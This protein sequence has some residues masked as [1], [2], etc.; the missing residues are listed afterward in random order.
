MSRTRLSVLLLDSHG[1]HSQAVA[2]C[3]GQIPQL[4]LHALSDIRW[5]AVRFSRVISSFHRYRDVGSETAQLADIRCVSRAVR[6]DVLLPV[7]ESSLSLLARHRD[8]FPHNLH[9]PPLSSPE[10]LATVANKFTLARRLEQRALPSPPTLLFTSLPA[11]ASDFRRLVFPALLKPLAGGGGCGIRRF[12]NSPALLQAL[13]AHPPEPAS[14]ILQAFVPGR[15]V[16]C[17]VLCRDGRILAHTIQTRL[18]PGPSRFTVDGAMT[19]TAHPAALAAVE[20]TM[21][22]LRW[23]GIAHL[24]LREDERDGSVQIIDFNPRYWLTL[25]GSLT[26]GVNFPH[27][28]CLTTLGIEFPPP[29]FQ[30]LNYYLAQAALKRLATGRRCRCPTGLRYVLRDPL[31]RM[32]N[33]VKSIRARPIV[34]T[35]PAMAVPPLLD[36]LRFPA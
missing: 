36:S 24:D 10:L 22:A 19:F 33:L 5:P 8:S 34:S 31:P 16:D 20:K 12:A 26:A 14:C 35:S 3:L 9:L 23:N 15:D 1:H 4:R 32:V 27:L 11:V 7:T 30:P 28:A 29:A 2:T 25:L 17:S 18:H 13:R 6:A 21:A